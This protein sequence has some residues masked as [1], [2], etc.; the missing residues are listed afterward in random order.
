MPP[1]RRIDMWLFRL[2]RQTHKVLGLLLSILFLMW[3]LSGVVMIY[4]GFPRVDHR[5]R[6]ARLAPLSAGLPPVDTL[7]RALPEQVQ[8]QSL[9][10]DMRLDRPV[11]HV[12]AKGVPSDWFA[13]SLCPVG[14][15]DFPTIARLAVQ[16]GGEAEWTVDTLYR[17][18]QWIPFGRLQREFPIYKFTFRDDRRQQI[19]VSSQTGDILQWTDR[20]ARFWASLGAVPHWVYFTA[21]RQHQDLWFNFMVWAAGLGAVMCFTGLWIGVVVLWRNRRRGLCSPY[22]RRWLRWHHVSGMVFG[23]FALTFVFSG[24][25]SMVDLPSW[26]KKSNGGEVRPSF[27]GRQSAMLAPETYR[28]DY[29]LLIDSLSGVKRIEWASFAGH[30]YYAVEASGGR[31]YIDAADSAALRPFRLTEDMVRRVVEQIHG[32]EADYTL[33][34]QVA[35][36]G[37]NPVPSGNAAVPVYKVTVHDELHTCHEFNPQTLQHQQTDDN[38]RLKGILYRGLHCLDFD[39][40][41]VRPVLW[42]VLM[43]TLLVGGIFLSLTGVVLT[44]QWLGRVFRKRFLKQ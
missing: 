18:D 6:M 20:R 23:V 32:K 30:P 12:R 10:V 43:Y 25:M 31:Q 17:L 7:C 8:P 35:G 37:G 1:E 33:E 4:H 13:D 9:S 15:P 11:F 44:F 36:N 14:N 34:L 41:T 3:F 22:K 16:L 39:A 26:L 24:M 40:L 19:Y 29:R 21:L 5:E 38:R 27:R 2:F 28:L 42:N